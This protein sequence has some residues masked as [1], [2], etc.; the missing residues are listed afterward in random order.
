[1]V[2]GCGGGACGGGRGEGQGQPT[3]QG[4]GV[5]GPNSRSFSAIFPGHFQLDQPNFKLHGRP[6]MR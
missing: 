3:R 2:D 4:G 5:A 1:M 6:N